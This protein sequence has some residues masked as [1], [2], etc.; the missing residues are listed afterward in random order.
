MLKTELQPAFCHERGCWKVRE[1][2]QGQAL[3][4]VGLEG[5]ED[6]NLIIRSLALLDFLNDMQK[7]VCL[8]VFV[9]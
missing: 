7:F 1:S 8:S 5:W 6:G 4:G 3:Q 9:E 2:K